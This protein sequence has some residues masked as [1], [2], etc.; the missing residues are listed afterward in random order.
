[1]GATPCPLLAPAAQV[2]SC[3]TNMARPTPS[4]ER[5]AEPRDIIGGTVPG[6]ATPLPTMAPELATVPS[7]PNGKSNENS[8]SAEGLSVGVVSANVSTVCKLSP[9]HR[10]TEWTEP[11]NEGITVG[12]ATM[13]G[14]VPL[15]ALV[16][17]TK[18][19]RPAQLS[20]S[21]P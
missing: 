17:L 12:P 19:A 14:M 8:M 15:W 9:D 13:L 2:R 1:M 5:A 6:T 3:G 7:P 11:R 10:R 4:K 20:L 21:K 16:K 18:P